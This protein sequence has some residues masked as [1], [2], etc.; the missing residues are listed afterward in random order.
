MRFSMNRMMMALT[1]M[2]FFSSLSMA[3]PTNLEASV[4]AAIRSLPAAQK[5]AATSD[6]EFRRRLIIYLKKLKLKDNES[7]AALLER[8][9]ESSTQFLYCTPDDWACLEKKP[10]VP[11]TKEFRVEATGDLG[12]PVKVSEPLKIETFFTKRW[13]QREMN[14]PANDPTMADVLGK[15]IDENAKDGLYLAIYGIDD[16]DDSMKPVYDSIARKVH[17]GVDTQAVVDVTNEGA[18]NSFP[19][20]Y[21]VVRNG[22]EFKVVDFKLADLNMSYYEPKED[23][24]SWVWGRPEWMDE[25]QGVA[26]ETFYSPELDR[27]KTRKFTK[28]DKDAAW[29]VKQPGGKSAIRLAFQYKSTVDLVHLMNSAANDDMNSKARI[30]FPVTNIMHN[31]FAVMKRGDHLSVWSGTTNIARSCMGNEEN[32]NM[33]VFVDNTA[34]AETFMA[35]F[36]EMHGYDESNTR[37]KKD[38]PSLVTGRFHSLKT[39]NTKRYFQFADGHEVRVHFSPTDDGEHRA[40]MPMIWSAKKGDTL[41]ISMFGCGGIE[42]VRA[43]Q[44]A[45]ARGVKILIALDKF[46]S[47]GTSSWV[48]DSEGSILE[49]NPYNPKATGNISARFSDWNGLNHQKVGTLTRANGRVETLIVGSQNWSITG[50]DDND[51]NMLTIRHKT[52]SLKAGEAF[53][54]DFDSFVYPLAKPIRTTADGKIIKEKSESLGAASDGGEREASEPSL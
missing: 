19:R 6:P 52:K 20:T 2:M 30:E 14:L 25:I 44:A 38:A 7:L 54:Q 4:D 12:K 28:Y 8:L 29:L 26:P 5:K 22:P 13:A 3:A 17:E 24:K 40:I 46:T 11:P 48:M 15:K 31:K 41:R 45:A 39:P 42:L 1:G 27:K 32:S 9:F 35:E 21:D 23:K 37:L 43:F 49:P 50:N 33:A 10:V 53:N 34:V 18:A 51:E 36:Q 16:I 47:S